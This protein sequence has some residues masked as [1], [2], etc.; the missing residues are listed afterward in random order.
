Q[1]NGDRIGTTGYCMGGALSLSTAGRFPDRV[2]AA[3]S[4][5]GGNLATDAVDSPH[6]LAP[7]IKARVYVAGA[8]ED[9]SFDD[10]QKQRL[11][12]ALR[13]ASVR[14]TVETYP[15][16]RHGWVPT[17]SPVYQPAGAERHFRTLIELFD[18]TLK[19]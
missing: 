5:H 19:D 3:A 14:H 10:A 2:A 9:S 11:I 6:L 4:F 18:A 12:D 13:A 8:V 16:A 7:R 15:D 1:V 17:D